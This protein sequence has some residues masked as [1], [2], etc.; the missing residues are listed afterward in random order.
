LKPDKVTMSACRKCGAEVTFR[1][2][3]GRVVPF[4]CHCDEDRAF[5][6]DSRERSRWT[7]CPVCGRGVYFVEYNGG[8]VW[9]DELGP[10]WPKHPC[11]DEKGQ[12]IAPKKVIFA[13][14]EVDEVGA[15]M[16]AN[17]RSDLGQRFMMVSCRDRVVEIYVPPAFWQGEAAASQGASVGLDFELMQA[18]RADGEAFDFW[19]V[20][21]KTC[22]RCHKRFVKWEGH[23]EICSA[24]SS[25]TRTPS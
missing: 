8:C 20:D 15:I 13:G 12:P 1:T 25:P 2:I 11:F 3:E 4:G 23:R 7:Y 18:V 14:I 22:G 5:Y 24:P 6:H 16:A 10:P 19:L 9:L 17:I 21:L